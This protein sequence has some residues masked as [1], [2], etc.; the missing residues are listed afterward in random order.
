MKFK[1]HQNLIADGAMMTG[2]IGS[3][4]WQPGAKMFFGLTPNPSAITIMQRGGDRFANNAEQA[5]TDYHVGKH[6]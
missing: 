1:G 6:K 4:R 5:S 3:P 2:E